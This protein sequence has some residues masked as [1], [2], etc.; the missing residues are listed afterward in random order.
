MRDPRRP[1]APIAAFAIVVSVSAFLVGIYPTYR[2]EAEMDIDAYERCPR[3]VETAEG[4]DEK[5]VQELIARGPLYLGRVALAVSFVAGAMAIWILGAEADRTWARR[6][7]LVFL[8]G[9]PPIAGLV[10]SGSGAT[11]PAV[12][13]DVVVVAWLATAIAALVRW[14]RA[15]VIL[16]AT[17]YVLTWVAM[18]LWN[19]SEGERLVRLGADVAA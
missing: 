16:L 10:V 7:S 11:S 8:V 17:F 14:G 12:A 9:V 18:L 15:R 4:W 13:S 1:R 19:D 3:A 5:C 6:M 2:L